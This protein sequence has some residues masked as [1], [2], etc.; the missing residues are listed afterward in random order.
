MLI[1]S[2][3]RPCHQNFY[4]SVLVLSSYLLRPLVSSSECIYDIFQFMHGVAWL[5]V[6]VQIVQ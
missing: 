6:D 2:N 3:E 4:Y 1:N 5:R